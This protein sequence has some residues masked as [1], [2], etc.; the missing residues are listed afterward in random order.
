MYPLPFKK[1][2]PAKAARAIVHQIEQLIL[3]GVLHPGE[4]LPSERELAAKFEVSRPTLRG[5]LSELEES[6][7]VITRPGAGDICGR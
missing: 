7:L 3:R 4:R 1:I 6:G 2:E 5:A